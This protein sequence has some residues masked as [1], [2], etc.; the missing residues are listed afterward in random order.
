MYQFRALYE[1]NMQ[2]LT[3][4]LN[5]AFSDYDQPICFTTESL[6]HYLTASTVDLSLSFGAFYNEQLV[7]VILNSVGIYMH[8][9]V[10]FDAGTGVVPEHRDKKVFSALFEYTIQQLKHHNIERYYL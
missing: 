10:V 6:K 5:L 3:T 7:A 9:R 8:Q 2:Q 1:V 4:C